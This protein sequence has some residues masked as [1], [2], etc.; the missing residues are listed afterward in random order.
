MTTPLL[1]PLEGGF[2]HHH[3]GPPWG[4]G[5][6]SSTIASGAVPPF[7]PFLGGLMF[8]LF[9][10]LVLG[11]I[12]FFLVRH[13]QFAPQS[14]A[15]SR[16]PESEAKKILAERF[17]RGDITT[18]EFMERASVLNWTPGSESYDIGKRRKKGL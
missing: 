17:A 9:M 12:V 11:T 7:A 2:G 5:D 18:D 3:H 4:A 6:P 16:S 14:L 15:G 8:F 10:L 1:I 13:G